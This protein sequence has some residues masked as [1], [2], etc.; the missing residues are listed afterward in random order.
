MTSPVEIESDQSRSRGG[1][2][3]I[4]GGRDRLAWEN[5]AVQV[6]ACGLA[7]AFNE[8]VVDAADH[9]IACGAI[10][11]EQVAAGYVIFGSST[12]CAVTRSTA[13]DW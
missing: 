4:L 6:F 10:N 7:E 9:Q 13:Q 8:D 1:V 2:G 5:L 12:R 3:G 11:V